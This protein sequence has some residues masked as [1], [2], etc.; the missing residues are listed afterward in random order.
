MK[1]YTKTGDAGETGLY[2]GTRVSKTDPRVEAYGTV[3]ELN[4]L[5]GLA[6]AHLN[7]V[8][9]D[10][11]LQELQNALFEVGADLATP[12]AA[13]TRG[14]I[15]AID[16]ADVAQLETEIDR[17][18]EELAPLET[19]VLPGGNASAAA[20]H[21]ARSVGRRAER[22]VIAVEQREEINPHVR[23]Y[24]NRLSDLL[25]VLARIVNMRAGVS[26]SAWRVR[27]RTRDGAEGGSSSG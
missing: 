20:L 26:E 21:V 6:R 22:R 17:Y 2:G 4:A 3:D 12:L 7:D 15:V 8:Q 16:E 13:K 25:F 10:R 27:V 11:T 19:F 23:V 1:I 18:S 24:L 14:K 9:V 5:L